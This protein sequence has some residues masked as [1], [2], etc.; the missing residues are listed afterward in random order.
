MK[1][2]INKNSKLIESVLLILI[3]ILQIITRLEAGN[4]K[5]YLHIDESYSYGLMNYDKVD[6]ID[7]ED[8]YNTW[9]D[10]EYYKDYLTISEDEKWDLSPVYEEQK[11]DVHPPFYYLLLRIAATFT[12]GEFSKWTGIGLNILI[13]IMTSIMIY[14]ISKV[15]FKNK[16]YAILMVLINGFTIASIET[17]IFIRMY[18]LN[19]LNLLIITYIHMKNYHKEKLEI[20]DLIL[21]SLFIIAGALTHYYYLVFVLVLY[22]MYMVHFIKGKNKTN[23]IRYTIAMIVSGILYLLIFPYSIVHVLFGY[24]G[25]GVASNL[26]S[27]ETMWNSLGKYIQILNLHV[28]NNVLIFFILFVS[29]YILIKIVKNKI[30]IVN[31]KNREFFLLFTPTLIYLIIIACIS[32]YQEIRYIMPICPAI[33]IIVMYFV[34]NVLRRMLSKEKTFVAMNLIFLLML[35]IPMNKN[36]TLEYMYSDMSELVQQTEE[37]SDLPTLYI[38]DKNNN[39]FMDDLYLFTKIDQSYIL[40][41]ELFSQEKIQEIFMDI[42]TDKGVRV[43]ITEELPHADEIYEIMEALNKD[44]FTEIKRLNAC[45]V[46]IIK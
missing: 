34:K 19:A 25:Q 44:S 24:R 5:A 42:N 33:I 20:K 3:I 13:F 12:I 8:F 31:F 39:R 6:I 46:Y 30:I 4:A 21:M 23:A 45:N 18:A 22:I 11:N 26:R 28:F 40:D 1:D 29:I 15:I 7:N 14:K 35:F 41:F 10:K 2:W 36:L 37:Y 38:L 17:T 32:P 9:H 43:I 27:F 16:L